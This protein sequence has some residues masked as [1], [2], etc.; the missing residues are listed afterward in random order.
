M[1]RFKSI[2]VGVDLSRKDRLVGKKLNR[3]ASKAYECAVNLAK[4]SGADLHFLYVLEVSVDVQ[5]RIGRDSGLSPT[6]LD[7]AEERMR[8]LIHETLQQG[9]KATG[10][11]VFGRSWVEITRE[12]MRRGHDLVMV[13]TREL[14]PFKTAL[15]GSIGLQL[16]RKCPCPVWISKATNC[17]GLHSILLANDGSAIGAAAIRMAAGLAELHDSELQ[18]LHSLGGYGMPGQPLQMS[19]EDV[20]ATKE[21]LATGIR[22]AG[23][24]RRARVQFAR[25]S[26]FC[27]AIADHIEDHRNELLVLGTQKLSGF[28]RMIGRDRSQRLL[29][30]IP[31]SLLAVKPKDFVSPVALDDFE[32]SSA[33]I[34][35]A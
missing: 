8:N 21:K 15:L 23:L 22:E 25:D 28:S 31:C 6:L 13:G 29:S 4:L 14:G 18:V 7:L 5:E 26:A 3:H 24:Q 1:H 35:V 27:T 16:L 11:V 10:S 9:V 30:K 32:A 20:L 17:S 12:V 19:V 33:T 2:L 34:G